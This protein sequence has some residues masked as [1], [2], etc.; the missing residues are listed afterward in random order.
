MRHDLFPSSSCQ[1]CVMKALLQVLY[2]EWVWPRR[3]KL[4]PHPGPGLGLEFHSRRGRGRLP[5][6]FILPSPMLCFSQVQLREQRLLT[7]IHS[8]FIEQGLICNRQRI[9]GPD[10][11]CANLLICW[12]LHADRDKPKR[13]RV[14]HSPLL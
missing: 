2:C 12:R 3:W 11:T 10:D 4:P 5:A 14:F 7:P 8:L 1:T 9:P 6:S 13:T